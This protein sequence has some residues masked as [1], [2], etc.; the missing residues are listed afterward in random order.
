MAKSGA[1]KGAKGIKIFNDGVLEGVNV[2][3]Y[4]IEDKKN[5]IN[6]HKK[7][8]ADPTYKMKDYEKDSIMRQYGKKV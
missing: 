8:K 5:V 7:M 1:S 4:T 2:A 3:N 6:Y